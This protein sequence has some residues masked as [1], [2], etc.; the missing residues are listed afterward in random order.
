MNKS[1]NTGGPI[2]PSHEEFH[3]GYHGLSVLD[4]FAAHA[5]NHNTFQLQQTADRYASVAEVA[6]KMAAAMLAEKRRI[7]GEK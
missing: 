2:A 3:W 5:I 6:Y 1:S 4:Y 7:E